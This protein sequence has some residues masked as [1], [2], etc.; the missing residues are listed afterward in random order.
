MFLYKHEVSGYYSCERKLFIMAIEATT[1]V[2]T[3]PIA[4]VAPKEA[5]K[6]AGTTAPAAPTAVAAAPT[7]ATAT[8]S[9]DSIAT[10]TPTEAQ[11]KKVDV[12]V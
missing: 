2:V 4:T 11:A 3:T 5:L 8:V 7:P 12:T 9:A 6:A 10:A 1:P